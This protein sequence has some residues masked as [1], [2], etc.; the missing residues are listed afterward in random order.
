MNNKNVMSSLK[1][2][3]T[4]EF[5][6][7]QN[8]LETLYSVAEEISGDLISPYDNKIN[9]TFK[10]WAGNYAME[11]SAAET[12]QDA[13]DVFKLKVANQYPTLIVE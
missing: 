7:G 1:E 6:G 9:S 3:Y 5:L 8:H 2:N 10:T 13:I 11:T 12:K 4:C